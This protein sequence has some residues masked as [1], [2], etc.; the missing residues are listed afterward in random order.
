MAD[1]DLR[2]LHHCRGLPAADGLDTNPVE[3]DDCRQPENRRRPAGRY[4]R[5]CKIWFILGWPNFVGLLMVFFLM[6][7][8]PV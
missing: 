5:L 4:H 6:M 2:D 1:A 7:A 8:K 3:K